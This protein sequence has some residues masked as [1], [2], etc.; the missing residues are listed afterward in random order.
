MLKL[1]ILKAPIDQTWDVHRIAKEAPPSTWES[2]FG[3]AVEELIEISRWLDEQEST[4]GQYYPNKED[5]FA[6]FNYTPLS[7]VKVV[8]LGQDP[9][10]QTISLNGK[11][12]PRAMGLSF[13]V[14]LGDEIPSS[15]KNIFTELK[16][17][18]RGFIQ[19]DHG[20]LRDWA[21]Q[22]I[23]LL[24]SCLT[25]QPGKAGSH[26]DIWLG[27][28]TKIFRAISIANPQCIYVLWGKKAQELKP[29]LG[30]K[31]IVFE[32]AH[33]SGL[34]AKKGFFKCNHFNLINETLIRQGR[35]G[36]N[37]HLKSSVILQ[38]PI[39]SEQQPLVVPRRNLVPVNMTMSYP[40]ISEQQQQ[41]QPK[42]TYLGMPTILQNANQSNN[43]PMLLP[44][45]PHTKKIETNTLVELKNGMITSTNPNSP[46]FHNKSKAPSPTQN[47]IIPNINNKT[48]TPSPIHVP[49]IPNIDFNNESF[50]LP[51]IRPLI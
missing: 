15:L 19:P 39:T 16:D 49:N 7:K 22:G 1:N 43:T 35:P 12:I 33:P 30:E 8:I 25:V 14:R 50:K 47:P 45:I 46:T 36:I 17:T 48:K 32:A 11:S 29:M 4:Y 27:F 24:N 41:Q 44:H 23:L 42:Q 38:N 34:S 51:D 10:H 26:G 28:I 18:I 40:A 2:V 20:D 5:L 6:A 9:Y 3:E 31:S 21:R 13:S 37:W